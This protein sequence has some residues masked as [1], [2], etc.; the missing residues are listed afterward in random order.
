MGWMLVDAPGHEGFVVALRK[1]SWRLVDVLSTDRDQVPSALQAACDCGW[2][3]AYLAP[4]VG[5]VFRSG[6]VSTA[7]YIQLVARELWLE[8][9]NHMQATQLIF[10]LPADRR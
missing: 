8:H 1:D 3:S 9:V 7:D 6:S 10:W 2:R 4:P 5:S